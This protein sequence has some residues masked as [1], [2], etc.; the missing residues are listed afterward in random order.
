MGINVVADLE[1]LPVA[2]DGYFTRAQAAGRGIEDFDLTR[3]VKRGYLK[4]VGHG[5]YRVAGAGHDHLGELRVAWLRLDPAR[6]AR[7]RMLHPD[8]WVSHESAGAVHGFGVFLADRHTFIAKHRVQPPSGVRIYRRS[9]GLDRYEWTTVEGFAVTTIVRTAV[10]L[11]AAHADGGHI[12]RFLSDAVSAGAV[13][14]GQL[15]RGGL[16]TDRIESLIAQGS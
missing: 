2:Q 1:G 7:Q 4:R 15:E 12:G 3:A 5:V 9:G 6:T 8:S 11:L 16:A 10:D 13:T 14:L